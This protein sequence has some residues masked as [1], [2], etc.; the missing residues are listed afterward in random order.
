MGFARFMASGAGRGARVVAGVALIAV[1]IVVGGAGGIVIAIV[2]V[3]PL[4]TGLLNI[5]LFAPLFHG[6]LRGRQARTSH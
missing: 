5:C 1:G 2:G 4:A 6:P 3:V